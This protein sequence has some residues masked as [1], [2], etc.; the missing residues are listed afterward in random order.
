MTLGRVLLASILGIILLSGTVGLG[1]VLVGLVNA[2]DDLHEDLTETLAVTELASLIRADTD[3]ARFVATGSELT[4]TDESRHEG[5][6]EPALID[7]MAAVDRFERAE[8]E[9]L[10]ELHSLLVTATERLAELPLGLRADAYLGGY[11][12]ARVGDS[13]HLQ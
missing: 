12:T 13:G 3:L 4:G 5:A 2:S 9:E 1:I 8:I 10:V 11:R 7:A 6:W